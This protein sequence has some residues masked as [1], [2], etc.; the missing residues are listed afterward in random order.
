MRWSRDLV[1]WH[2]TQ[3]DLSNS[4]KSYIQL[5]TPLSSDLQFTLNIR[6]IFGTRPIPDIISSA[7]QTYWMLVSTFFILDKN[8]RERFFEESFF[9]SNIKPDI[10]VE[11]LFLTMSNV[12]VNFQAWDL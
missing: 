7:L 2:G 8:S 10:I 4:T 6:P 5:K 3:P 9:L 1:T 11:M 12:D